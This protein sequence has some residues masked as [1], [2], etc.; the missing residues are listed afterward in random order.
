M[1]THK[2]SFLSVVVWLTPTVT[3]DRSLVSPFLSCC[4]CYCNSPE[5]KSHPQRGARYLSSKPIVKTLRIVPS[6]LLKKKRFVRERRVRASGGAI[7]PIAGKSGRKRCSKGLRPL[8][9]PL[10]GHA[11]SVSQQPPDHWQEKPHR[12]LI[13]FKSNFQPAIGALINRPVR[14]M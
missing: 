3:L 13:R 10:E 7:F 4:I 11:V 8:V 5:I 9:F 2:C 14:L 12:P 6:Y 1:V